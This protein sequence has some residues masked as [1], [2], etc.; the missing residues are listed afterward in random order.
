MVLV[1]NSTSALTKKTN[2]ENFKL[3]FPEGTYLENQGSPGAS[4][5]WNTGLDWIQSDD[6][7]AWV[8]V[9]DDDDEWF[10]NHLEICSKQMNGN[11]AVL[12]GIQILIDGNVK[13]KRYQTTYPVKTFLQVTPDG[14][15][16][17]RLLLSVRSLE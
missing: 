4:G 10:E 5:T 12:S 6:P 2:K 11:D 9:I 13:R 7:D 14:R 17:T 16:R 8:A 15:V 3:A 1:D